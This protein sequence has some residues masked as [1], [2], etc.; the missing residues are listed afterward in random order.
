[1]GVISTGLVVLGSDSAA[2]FSA[3]AVPA[4]EL[5][6]H[7]FTLSSPSG[8]PTVTQA[9]AEST[10]EKVFGNAATAAQLGDCTQVASTVNI[11]RLCWAVAI[12]PGNDT[13]VSSTPNPEKTPNQ[14]Y[15][16]DYEYV[17]LDAG[18]GDMIIAVQHAPT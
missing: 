3:D 17:L 14:I 7:G 1:V 2:A 5:A 8:S 11:G 9:E 18:T 6:A 16:V 4:S 12:N 13:I 15:K 10:A